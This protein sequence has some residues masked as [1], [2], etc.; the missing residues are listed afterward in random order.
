MGSIN[1]LSVLLGV[2]IGMYVVPMI[3]AKLGH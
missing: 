2:I 3:R 1:W